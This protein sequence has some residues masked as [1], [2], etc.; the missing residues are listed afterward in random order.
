MGDY[1]IWIGEK[2]EK[3]HPEMTWEEIMGYVQ[4]HELP[5]EYSIENYLKECRS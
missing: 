5:E 4:T 1:I 3:E 2:Y